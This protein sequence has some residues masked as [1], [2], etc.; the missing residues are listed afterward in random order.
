MS[1]I[2]KSLGIVLLA[3]VTIVPVAYAQRGGFRG[4]G[5]FHGGF[6]GGFGVGRGFYGGGFYGPGYWGWGPGWYYPYYYGGYGPPAGEVQIKTKDK[7]NSVY[8]DGGFAGRTGELKNFYLRPGTH[9]LELRTPNGVAFYHE[10]VN[11]LVGKKIKIDGN[12]PGQP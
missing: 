3:L 2:I 5:G 6:G 9:L 8:I 4:G 11:V 10:R 7:G 1:R 12:L